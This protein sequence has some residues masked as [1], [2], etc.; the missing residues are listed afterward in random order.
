MF[1]PIG[2][3]NRVQRFPAVTAILIVVNFFFLAVVMVL[4]ANDHPVEPWFI[5]FA[6]VPAYFGS[7]YYPETLVTAIFLHAGWMHLIGNMLFLWTFG[8]NIEDALGHLGFLGFYLFCGVIGTYLHFLSAPDSL[9]PLVG[10]SGAISGV[11][12][13]YYIGFPR[14]P[15]RIVVPPL[16]FLPFH[17][18]ALTLLFLWAVFQLALGVAAWDVEGGGTA[19]WTHIGGF[20]AG[21]AVF[22][23]LRMAGRAQPYCEMRRILEEESRAAAQVDVRGLRKSREG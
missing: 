10:A 22:K 20:V 19:Y 7:G 23:A 2:D 4:L 6:F 13:A 11:V 16:V 9:V 5:R 21:A 8:P 12:G 17:A 18:R 14:Q 15:I 1:I 3:R